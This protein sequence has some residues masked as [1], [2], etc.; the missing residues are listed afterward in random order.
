MRSR[1]TFPVAACL[2]MLAGGLAFTA[3]AGAAKA[4]GGKIYVL[5]GLPGVVADVQI[6]GRD[7]KRQVK[8]GSIVGPLAVGSGRHQVSLVPEK[9]APIT[10]MVTVSQGAS[11]DVVAH[12][13]AEVDGKARLTAFPNDLSAV[14]RGKT[15]LAVAHTAQ[16]PPAD[17]RVDR[18]PLLRNVA[19]AEVLTLEV[20]AKTYT[21]D[22]VATGTSGPAVFGPADVTPKAGTLTR[23]FAFGSP[24]EGTMNVLVHP[25]AISQ[26]GADAPSSVQTGT[27]GQLAAL[28]AARR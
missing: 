24:A 7:S 12:L 16:V 19:N 20:P 11:V 17:I 25:L 10:G 26:Q 22:I 23:V 6:D 21:V 27:G 5:H 13:P 15:R 14:G 18:K 3:P 2:L 28:L 9:G 8:V 1:R 4:S